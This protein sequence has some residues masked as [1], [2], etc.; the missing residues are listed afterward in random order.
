MD[1][2]PLQTSLGNAHTGDTKLAQV[3]CCATQNS[4]PY[5]TAHRIRSA[6]MGGILWSV[7]TPRTAVGMH[8]I[9]P[10]CA[11]LAHIMTILL[12][13]SEANCFPLLYKLLRFR[14][15]K[16]ALPRQR[17]QQIQALHPSGCGCAQGHGSVFPLAT[18][19]SFVARGESSI[20]YPLIKYTSSAPSRQIDVACARAQML[21]PRRLLPV[22]GRR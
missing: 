4:R 1:V 6:Q 13:P 2:C 10:R 9:A 18:E 5:H 20:L 15:A 7:R 11:R 14:S 21:H 19:L 17:R 12:F 22:S 8:G 3:G 16:A